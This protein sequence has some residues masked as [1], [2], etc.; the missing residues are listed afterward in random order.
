MPSKRKQPALKAINESESEED[1]DGE[2]LP[3]I[4]NIKRSP[5][6]KAIKNMQDDEEFKKPR[7]SSYVEE[8]KRKKN[9][10]AFTA[11]SQTNASSV[12][13]VGEKK[14]KLFSWLWELYDIS[15]DDLVRE[16][17]EEILFYLKYLKYTSVLLLFMSIVNIP[18]II[19]YFN[20]SDETTKI[21]SYL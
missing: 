6:I 16:C 4:T 8:K 20:C 2:R 1:S 19:V 18:T 21:E 14:T 5:S 9:R 15:D 13:N 10:V 3:E 7:H 11:K 17:G 12:D